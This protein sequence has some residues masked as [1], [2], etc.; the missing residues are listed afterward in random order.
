MTGYKK[1]KSKIKQSKQTIWSIYTCLPIAIVWLEICYP[2]NWL[3]Y[4]VVV[5]SK[6]YASNQA[7]LNNGIVLSAERL[8]I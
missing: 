5:L 2:E 8:Q 4:L 6:L 3:Q 1:S 7:G